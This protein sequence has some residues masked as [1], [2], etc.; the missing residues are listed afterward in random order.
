MYIVRLS[1]PEGK[2]DFKTFCA[3][4]DAKK[5]FNAGCALVYGANG[6][7]VEEAAIF[8]VPGEIDSR[9]AVEAVKNGQANILDR[10]LWP[11]MQKAA[12]ELIVGGIKEGKIILSAKNVV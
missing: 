12:D 10:D 9:K 2:H 11:E 5:R 6:P 1:L 4:S 7:D 3:L 8:E